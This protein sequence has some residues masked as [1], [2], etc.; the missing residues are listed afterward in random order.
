[1]RIGIAHQLILAFLGLTLVLLLLTLGLARWSFERGFLDYSI[2]LEQER[3]KRLAEPLVQGYQG[4]GGHWD[5]LSEAGFNRLLAELSPRL[6][7]LG[8]PPGPGHPPPSH[9]HPPPPPPWFRPGPPSPPTALLDAHGR[10]LAGMDWEERQ[11]MPAM[12]SLDA[13]VAERDAAGADAGGDPQVAQPEVLRVPLASRGETIGELVSLIP[14]RRFNTPQ[15]T[16]FA[17]QQT[18]ASLWI[19]LTGLLVAFL[20]SLLLARTLC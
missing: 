13:L 17:R 19:G 20:L 7:G 10:H 14:P 2:A 11:A 18:V 5:W 8:R 15:A 6:P 16:A 3:L 9:R 4:A 1:V 12:G